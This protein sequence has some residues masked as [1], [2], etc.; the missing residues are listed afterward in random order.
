MFTKVFNQRL[1]MPIGSPKVVHAFVHIIVVFV[2]CTGYS[3]ITATTTAITRPR[4]ATDGSE[5]TVAEDAV[6][7]HFLLYVTL[8][9]L[10]ATSKT[11][12]LK[13]PEL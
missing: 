11:E 2:W 9:A 12:P 5:S 6:P 8:F 3:I 1:A 7:Q 13:G 10:A 4:Y